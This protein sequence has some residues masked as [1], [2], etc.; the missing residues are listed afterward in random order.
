MTRN[1]PSMK[2]GLL[3]AGPALILLLTGCSSGTTAK[4]A[5]E[6]QAFAPGMKNLSPEAK[7]LREQNERQMSL[8]QSA[9]AA[10]GHPRSSP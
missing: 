4:S 3:L 10:T 5:E 6:M 2:T 8:R 9:A 7:A 1:L